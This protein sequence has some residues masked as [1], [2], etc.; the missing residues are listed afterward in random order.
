M[1]ATVSELVAQE[2]TAGSTDADV[3]R[4]LNAS[5]IEPPT[6]R[7]WTEAMLVDE[8]GPRLQGLVR[9]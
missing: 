8:F 9:R 3:V 6:G 1:I 2:R 4:L 5:S 7:Q